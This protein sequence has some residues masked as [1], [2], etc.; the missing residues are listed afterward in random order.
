MISLPQIENTTTEREPQLYWGLTVS[1]EH[2]GLRKDETKEWKSMKLS[3]KNGAGS[4]W[5]ILMDY[6]WRDTVGTL[7]LWMLRQ[8][9]EGIFNRWLF[10]ALSVTWYTVVTH[11]A[12]GYGRER[13]RICHIQWSW[14]GELYLSL[15]RPKIN[16][17]RNDL[18]IN[19]ARWMCGLWSTY[20][21]CHML[22]IPVLSPY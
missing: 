16:K 20:S 22:M 13:H 8:F 17:L 11:R 14:N 7:G 4:R 21:L 18:L 19:V 5:P 12:S 15:V 9:Q 1:M 10:L 3:T 6:D 2:S